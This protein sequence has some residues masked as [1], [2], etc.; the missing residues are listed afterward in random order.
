VIAMLTIFGDVQSGNCLKVKY[1][2]DHLG[3]AYEWVDV[4][5][6]KGESRTAA[7]LAMNPQ[8]Q[9][10]LVRLGDGTCLA[11]SNAIL[12]YLARGTP[13]LPD[14]PLARARVDEWLFWEQNSHE[15]FVAGTIFQVVY[16]KRSAAEREAWRVKRA[17]GALDLMEQVLRERSFFAAAT[18]TVADIALLAYTRRAPLGGLDL[19]QR[20]AVRAWIARCE[21]QLGIDP[22]AMA[23]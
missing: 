8:G 18:M 6:M 13:L 7:F 11:Q 4:D 21:G 22:L 16:L 3:I 12:C 20:P 15:F 19:S 1:L 10:P 17:E 5:I 23:A 9:V 2:A 14:A